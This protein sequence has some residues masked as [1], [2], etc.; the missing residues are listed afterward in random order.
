MRKIIRYCLRCFVRCAATR[1]G[2]GRGGTDGRRLWHE[3]NTVHGKERQETAPQAQPDAGKALVYVFGD[4]DIDNVTLRVGSA[5]TRWG[6][7]R[8]E[9]G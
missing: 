8:L 2:P 4:E 7:E 3:R 5:I 1:P 9:H 6:V